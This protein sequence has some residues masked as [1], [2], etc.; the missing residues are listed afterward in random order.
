MG[1]IKSLPIKRTTLELLEKHP[2]LFSDDFEKNKIVLSKI[3]EADKKTRNSIAGYI[4]RIV[5][6]TKAKK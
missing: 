2:D 4:M 1:R 6:R 3:V 5:K